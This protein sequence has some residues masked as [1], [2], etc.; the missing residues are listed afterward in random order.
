MGSEVLSYQ[1]NCVLF[2]VTQQYILSTGR[3][4]AAVIDV[5]ISFCFFIF[6]LILCV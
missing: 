4:A 5:Q 3:L 2:S 1:E 6:I